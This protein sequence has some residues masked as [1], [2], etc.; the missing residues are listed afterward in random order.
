MPIDAVSHPTVDWHAI[1]WPKVYRTVHRLQARI[2]KAVQ[3]GQWRKVRALQRLLTRSSSG[4]ALAVRRVTENRGRKTPGVDGEVWHT[5]EKKATA[6]AELK[7]QGY[8]PLPLRRVYIP[9]SNMEPGPLGRLS[10][11]AQRPL[12]IPAMK[13]RAMQALYLLALD[14]VAETQADKNSYG[15]R[16]GRSTADAL[17]QSF[18]VLCRAYSPSWILE[19]D[20]RACFDTISHEWLEPHIPIEKTILRK[21]LKAGYIDHTSFHPT[22]EGTPQGAIISPVM[23]NMVLDGLEKELTDTFGPKTSHQAKKAK[24]NLVRYADDMVRHEAR[25]VHGAR[26]PTAGR[27]AVSLSP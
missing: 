5:P 7:P 25:Y 15:F 14:P 23:C 18:N 27:R 10:R 22:E 17:E 3:A 26:A 20:I 21:W 9:K 11:T 12:S 24:V 1:E 4:K 19:V 16:I 6:V 13:D 8:K 2:V